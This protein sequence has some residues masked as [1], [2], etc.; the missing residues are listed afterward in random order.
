[1]NENFNLEKKMFNSSCI[2]DYMGCPRLFYYTWIRGLKVKV[3]K[4]A[5]LFGSAFHE[6][7]LTWYKTGD[8]EKSIKE[9][10]MLPTVMTDDHRTKEW[11]TAIFK[12][13]VDRYRT[14][15]GK[16]LHLE[17]KFRVEIGDR[18]YAGKIDRIEE[19]TGQIYV[20]DHKTTTRLG[21]AFFEGYRPHPQIDGYCFACKELM[22]SCSG[23]VINGISVAKNP[24]DRF[25]RFPSSRTAQEMEGWKEVFTDTTNDILRDVERMHF[26]KRTT[27]CNR[28][29]KCKFWQLC[30]YGDDE[31]YVEQNFRIEDMTKEVEKDGVDNTEKEK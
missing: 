14:E 29:G 6:V 23:A 16:T 22:G 3:E 10:D 5:L 28:W 7:L 12:Q 8:M 21:L 4:P 26:P 31:R 20:D 17:V 13:Y 19:W 15:V 27:H 24:K 1:V 2:S 25:Q 9:F 18:I 11:G 30:V